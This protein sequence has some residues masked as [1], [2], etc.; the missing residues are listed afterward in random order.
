MTVT[1]FYLTNNTK[2]SAQ[3]AVSQVGS[4][5]SDTL[6]ETDIASSPDPEAISGADPDN[7]TSY[8]NRIKAGKYSEKIT[9]KKSRIIE[10]R[11]D[12]DWKNQ[13]VAQTVLESA[14]AN[15]VDDTIAVSELIRQCRR[16]FDSERQIKRE[17]DRVAI[18]VAHEKP[19]QSTFLSGTGQPFKFG[20]LSARYL[21]AMRLPNQEKTSKDQL[22]AW[23]EYT[24]NAMDFTWQNI[25]ERKPLGLLVFG[26]SLEAGRTNNFTIKN[27]N[28]GQAF[29]LAID[30]AGQNFSSCAVPGF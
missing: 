20:R 18:S 13:L 3:E 2:N 10:S 24:S 23:L 22:V 5:S 4:E 12:I 16:G 15:N 28:Y 6:P 14:L 1:S 9:R 17:L 7:R 8:A 19:V 11:T 25:S 27:H 21:Y 30:R 26:Q 29:V